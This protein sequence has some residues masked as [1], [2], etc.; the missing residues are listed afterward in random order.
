MMKQRAIFH[1]AEKSGE[2]AVFVLE[3][4]CETKGFRYG[5][6]VTAGS[7]IC[8]D[9]VSVGEDAARITI[10]K[11]QPSESRERMMARSDC[12]EKRDIVAAAGLR[13]ASARCIAI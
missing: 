2:A 12:M 10:R 5:S 7:S 4:E 1:K 9:I 3:S 13:K 11:R 8:L 6:V